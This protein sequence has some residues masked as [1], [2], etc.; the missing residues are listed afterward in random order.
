[1]VGPKQIK[2]FQQSLKSS[3]RFKSLTQRYRKLDGYANWDKIALRI[4]SILA[5][6]NPNYH[7]DGKQGSAQL[8]V[9]L[10]R[11]ANNC[12]PVYW[13]DHHLAQ[14]FCRTELPDKLPPVQ[15]P[16][17]TFFLMLPQHLPELRRNLGG[18]PQCVAV[19]HL[20]EGERLHDVELDSGVL[21]ENMPA[22]P[23]DLLVWALML[24]SQKTLLGH[25]KLD[26]QTDLAVGNVIDLSVS[27]P[28]QASDDQIK[29]GHSLIT[30]LVYQTILYLQSYPE[31]GLQQAIA[32]ATGVGFGSS[33][34]PKQQYRNRR[35][36]GANY[37][38]K[39]QTATP[40]DRT[41]ASPI[42]HWRRGHWRRQPHGPG[43]NQSKMIWIQPML[44]DPGQ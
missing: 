15:R 38:P 22:P 29:T 36:V 41:H 8:A 2:Q 40:S 37:R 25:N 14:A 12:G 23:S 6:S 11:A 42:T 43:R 34:L 13:L 1:M 5:T 27:N 32:P 21:L 19:Q 9:V 35:W 33:K 16:L 18:I 4:T 30:H 44:I 7:P 39:H 28:V 10:H 31:D 24:S 26:G 17:P 3:D 20:L